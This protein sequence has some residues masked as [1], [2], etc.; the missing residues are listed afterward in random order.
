MLGG[1][2]RHTK[3]QGFFL[4]IRRPPRSTL[5][6]YTTLFRSEFVVP[7]SLC[8]RSRYKENPYSVGALARVNVLGERLDGKAGRALKKYFNA[9]WKANPLF[10]NAAQA[11]EILYA[12]E[13]IP[14]LVDKALKI[15]DDPPIMPYKTKT[16]QGTGL[17]EA[18]R[19]LL[20][21]HYEIKD[22]LG[23]T[24]EIIHTTTQTGEDID[25]T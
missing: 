2:A 15:P 3:P 18:P 8:K 14:E 11:L 5:F 21:H 6:P 16:G 4:R 9:R 24:V 25:H 13:Q 12:F 20:I 17:V 10:H 23:A 19:G 22:G 1:R 7:H